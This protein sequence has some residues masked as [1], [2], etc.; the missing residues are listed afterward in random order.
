MASA[1]PTPPPVAQLPFVR[2]LGA[3]GFL[4]DSGLQFLQQLWTLATGLTPVTGVYNTANL[5]SAVAVGPGGHAAASDSTVVAAGNF[6]AAYAGG[7]T[8]FVP[9]YSD[10]VVW[11]IG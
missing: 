5:P 6:G 3:A 4:T 1:P 10:G 11:R 9:L 8:H 2:L 7:G